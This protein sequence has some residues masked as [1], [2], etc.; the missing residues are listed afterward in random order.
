MIINKSSHPSPLF[1]QIGKFRLLFTQKRRPPF[2][3]EVHQEI[4][5]HVDWRQKKEQY[6]PKKFHKVL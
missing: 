2:E 1:D 3:S 6:Y 5:R 4:G